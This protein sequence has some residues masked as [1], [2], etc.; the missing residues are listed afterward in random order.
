MKTTFKSIGDAIGWPVDL[1]YLENSKTSMHKIKKWCSRIGSNDI[2]VLYYSGGYANN[3]AYNGLWPLAKIGKGSIPVDILANQ[4]H[5]RNARLSLVFADC[6][7]KYIKPR[8]IAR[9]V[10]GDALERVKK[11][12]IRQQ[13]RKAWLAEK[14]TLTMSSTKNGGN[15]YG[16]ILDPKKWG[17]FTEALLLGIM[18][19]TYKDGSAFKPSK[20]PNFI[21]N[22]MMEHPFS[23]QNKQCPLYVSTIVEG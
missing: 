23:P 6:Y 15:A 21:T 14:G 3:A 2:A 13:I 12:K 10:Y 5:S 8:G 20:V 7:N 22:H 16:V 1:A 4:L 11:K 19:G 9:R 17:A 18:W